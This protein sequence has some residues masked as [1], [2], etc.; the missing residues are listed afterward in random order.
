MPGLFERLFGNRNDAELE[1]RILPL[2]QMIVM[3]GE[4]HVHELLAMQQL[5]ARLGVSESRLAQMMERARDGDPI[6]IPT[7][8]GHRLELLAGAALIMTCDGDT[9]VGELEYYLALA[10]RMS[11]PPDV[12]TQVLHRELAAAKQLNH[13][14]DVEGDFQAALRALAVK[15]VTS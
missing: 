5:V 7:D 15:V 2:L 6:P 10:G 13:G 3:D 9:A 14:V 4:T 11:I 8:P 12:A 1:A